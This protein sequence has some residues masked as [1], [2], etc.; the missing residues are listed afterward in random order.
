[1]VRKTS[2]QFVVYLQIHSPAIGSGGFFELELNLSSDYPLI[3]LASRAFIQREGTLASDLSQQFHSESFS[4]ERSCKLVRDCRLVDAVC[5][6]ECDFEQAV[7]TPSRAYRS[8]IL[9]SRARGN[10]YQTFSACSTSSAS[11]S[12]STPPIVSRNCAALVAPTIAEVTCG[13]FKTHASAA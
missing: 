5:S 4:F 13:C 3:R 1:M 9:G 6:N 10:S 8:A 12:K 7:R 11:S 2:K